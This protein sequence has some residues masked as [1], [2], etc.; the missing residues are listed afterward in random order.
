[1]T[2]KTLS[3]RSTHPARSL[4][5]WTIKKNGVIITIVSILALLLKPG[6]MIMSY[7]NYSS[8]NEHLHIYGDSF[9]GN[10]Y[11]IV[12][13]FA[14]EALLAMMILFLT[15][16]ALN[17]MHS[18]K[19]SD[20]FNAI[21]VTRTSLLLTKLFGVMVSSAIPVVLSFTGEIVLSALVP[22]LGCAVTDSV[23]SLCHVLIF[24]FICTAFAGLIST[25]CGNTFDTIISVLIL[26][27]GWPVIVMI[28]AYYSSEFLFG[29]AS[30]PKEIYFLLS[31]FG[32]LCSNVF[33]DY[34]LV[35]TIWTYALWTVF[36]ILLLLAAVFLCRRRKNEFSG[37]SYAFKFLPLILQGFAAIIFGY[38][39][40]MI[41]SMG[42]ISSVL[43][44]VFFVIGAALGGIIFGAVSSRGFKTIVYSLIVAAVSV[45]V[46]LASISF[47]FFDL[48]GF[49]D[50][51]PSLDSVEAVECTINGE[52]ATFDEKDDIER[53]LA[54]HREINQNKLS[55]KGDDELI[56][57][58]STNSGEMLNVSINYKLTFERKLSRSYT[59][60]FDSCYDE[61]VAILSSRSYIEKTE[62]VYLYDDDVIKHCKDIY[63]SSIY[64]SDEYAYPSEKDIIEL[65]EAYKKDLSNI[66]KE[67]FNSDIE[68]TISLSDY[69]EEAYL[70]PYSYTR[71]IFN[72]KSSY[73]HTLKYLKENSIN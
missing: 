72:V 45:G 27:F 15:V 32:R 71:I 11:Y 49:E 34:S 26:S 35:K 57:I 36:G 14:L 12:T 66:T 21:P 2:S 64:H 55:D 37:N 69:S 44:F 56:F 38:I 25:I 24:I 1:M 54:L 40:G 47:I 13:T 17:Y 61:I 9:D 68:Y 31:P 70:N 23:F 46:F 29:F 16:W 52:K 39:L 65:V 42:S 20:L 60:E 48:T 73:Y 7:L 63:I 30:F 28:F 22:E 51:I 41:F 62:D 3:A 4:F 10:K 59:V 53:I 19:V 43:F 18:K 8:T 50:R 33:L 67:N 5:A 58:T 6:I